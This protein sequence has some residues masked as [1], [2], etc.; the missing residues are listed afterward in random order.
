[1]KYTTVI[2]LGFFLLN[3]PLIS[4]AAE[5]AD[6]SAKR[7]A[8]LMQKMK[9]DMEAE[10]AALQSTFEEEKKSLSQALNQ[11]QIMQRSHASQ[12]KNQVKQTQQV[13]EDN[14][15]LQQ[16]KN[17]LSLQLSQLKA[18]MDEKDAQLLT[19]EQQLKAAQV[20]QH[21]NEQQQKLLLAKVMNGQK[22]IASCVD[23][24]NKLYAYGNALVTLYNDAS[25]YQRFLRSEPFFQLKRVELENLFQ[26]KQN[27]LLENRVKNDMTP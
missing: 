12:L 10:K 13:K 6:K 27:Q 3:Q 7:A 22:E 23:K 19:F 14:I 25:V 17:E 11:S 5:K 16:E 21:S 20:A 1:M 9:M 15:K 24:N 2:L 4:T 26:E 18:Q 8:I